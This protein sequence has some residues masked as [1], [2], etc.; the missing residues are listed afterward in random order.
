MIGPGT[1]PAAFAATTVD[2]EPITEAGLAGGGLVG[3]FS[4]T[5]GSCEEWLP[6]FAAAAGALPGGP[7]QALAVV[8]AET[9]TEAADMVSRL[10]DV[11]MV[12]VEK[13]GG[14]LSTAFKISGYP[15]MCRLNDDGSVATFKPADVVTVPVVA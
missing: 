2:A 13:D 14:P 7:R 3:F 5:C 10:R 8:V 9:E 4:P 11:A 15:A 1:R 6:Q 12:V